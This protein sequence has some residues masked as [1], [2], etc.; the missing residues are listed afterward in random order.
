VR[1]CGEIKGENEMNEVNEEEEEEEEGV[2][3]Q[4]RQLFCG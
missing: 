1:D 4:R 3:F 2:V